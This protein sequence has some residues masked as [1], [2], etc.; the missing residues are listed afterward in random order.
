MGGIR[1]A[2][3]RWRWSTMDGF[4]LAVSLFREFLEWIK[5]SY[6]RLT[7]ATALRLCRDFLGSVVK[8]KQIFLVFVVTLGIQ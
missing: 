5:F 1:R 8:K 3:T 6:H 7:E 2:T 4:I